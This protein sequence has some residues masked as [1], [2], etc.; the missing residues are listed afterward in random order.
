MALT[1]N[2]T[3][4]EFGTVRVGCDGLRAAVWLSGEHDL[5]TKGAVTAALDDAVAAEVDVV[6][7]LTDARFMDASILG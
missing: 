7:D 3:G 5:T 1:G 4:A 2:Q 6:V